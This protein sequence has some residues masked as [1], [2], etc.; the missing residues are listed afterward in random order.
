MDN[1]GSVASWAT[2]TGRALSTP[3]HRPSTGFL[4]RFDRAAPAAVLAETAVFVILI[5]LAMRA[6]PGGTA[7]DPTARGHDFWLNYLCD[8]ERRT[9]LDGHPNDVGAAFA[10][11]AMVV[12]GS[13]S[14]LFWRFLPGLFP[15]RA[16][17]GGVVRLFGSISAGGIVAVGL[18]P[19]DQ[20]PG[21]HPILM[22]VAGGTGIGAAVASVLGLF[23]HSARPYLATVGAC[24][25]LL[26][27]IDLALYFGQM[28]P[29]APS[30]R[31][32]AVLERAA[33]LV[34]LGW[35]ALVALTVATRSRT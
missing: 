7:W 19:A 21:L 14:F 4:E 6:Y 11:A 22:L 20:F 25:V 8:L 24:A 12:L 30:M 32:V 9:A 31:A 17:L 5:A 15:A 35:R 33:L 26:S 27:A 10:R 13:G 1:R 16:A 3:V 23:A 2:G 34:A 18:L 28:V 29:G